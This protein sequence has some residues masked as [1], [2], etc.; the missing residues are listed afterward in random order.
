[1]KKQRIDEYGRKKQQSKLY[2]EQEQ[3]CH[4]WLSQNLNP[5]KTA[6]IMTMLEQMVETRSW[7]EARGLIGDDRCRI[8]N[9]HS[10]T[11]EHLVA[12]CTKLA[13]SKYL[14]RYSR[15]LMVLAVAWAKQQELMGQEAIWY[16]QKWDRGMVLENDRAKLVW[17]FENLKLTKRSGSAT[18]HAHSKTT[19]VQR[20]LRR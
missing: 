4:V 7:K 5:G 17:D 1:M 9:Q 3:E 8:C 10:E 2:R 20:G 13:N 12:G 15:A 14:T 6:A 16:Q 19:L 11:V 18:W